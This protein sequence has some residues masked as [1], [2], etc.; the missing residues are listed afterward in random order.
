MTKEQLMQPRWKCIA[1]YP[2]SIWKVGEILTD[3][4][5]LWAKANLEPFPNI[6]VRL[7]WWEDRQE[8][9]MPEYVKYCGTIL[10]VKKWTKNIEGEPSFTWEGEKMGLYAYSTLPATEEE[11]KQFK[12]LQDGNT[13]LKNK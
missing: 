13:Q 10:K 11:Y 2:Q 1:D 8:S 12:K 5:E 7:Q 6:F 4:P 3:F 9:E